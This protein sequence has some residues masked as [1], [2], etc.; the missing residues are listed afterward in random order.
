MQAPL[1]LRST[2]G[3]GSSFSLV[4][5]KLTPAALSRASSS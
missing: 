1:S 2:P 5:P 4:L 3:R